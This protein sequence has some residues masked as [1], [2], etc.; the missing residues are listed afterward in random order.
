[1]VNWKV[2][3]LSLLLFALPGINPI[4]GADDYTPGDFHNYTHAD[5]N[6]PKDT[7]QYSVFVPK[8]YDP[9]KSYPLVYYLHGGGNGRH[10]PNQGKRNIVS[11]RL[12]DNKRTT[13]GGYSKN[14]PNFF[15]YILVSPV[16][17]VASWNA[18][19]FKRLYDHV[20]SKVSI[21]EKRVYVTGFSMGGQGTWRVG[22]GTD[23]SYN[24]AAMM[25]LGAWGCDRVRRG[26][27]PETCKTLRTPVWVMHC[28]LDHVSKISEQLT[29]FH[30]HLKCGGY[31]RF[32]MIPG[33]GHISR[34]PNDREFF[35]MRMGW[36]LAQTYG[37]PFNYVIKIHD[38]TIVKAVSGERPYTG[39]EN[40]Y[41]FYE[42]GTVIA[43]TAEKMKDN[44]PFVRWACESGEFADGLSSSTFFTVPAGDVSIRAIYGLK[45]V[46]LEIG[47]GTAVPAE[48]KQGEIVTVTANDDDDEKKFTFWTTQSKTIEIAVPSNR[49][50]KFV[51]PSENVKITA[52]G[53]RK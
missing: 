28:P 20:K 13:D 21:D 29:L 51:M 22:C 48:P 27:T 26:S 12:I 33:K 42:P 39:N 3:L 34:G 36:M 18:G 38:G 50:F 10:H 47:G 1:M 43:I 7:Y 8:D 49:S 53:T 35:N 37:T 5:G 16:K 4:A 46:T 2:L 24:I 32:T 52:M 9:D 31:G 40:R 17:P 25:P 14:D 11:S 41:G 19:I 30:S 6:V 45:K 44:E 23:D 15:G